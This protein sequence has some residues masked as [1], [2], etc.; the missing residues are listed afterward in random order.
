MAVEI[1]RKLEVRTAEAPA[2]EAGGEDRWAAFRQIEIIDFD[3]RFQFRH[4]LG[5]LSRFFVELE[6]HRLMGTRCAACGQ[7]WLPPRVLCPEDMQVTE[8]VELA[9]HGIL[10]AVSRSAYTL[11]SDGGGAQTLHLGYV[12]VEGASTLMLQQIRPRGGVE[13][14]SGAVVEVVWAEGT[15]SHP[16]ELFWFEPR[17]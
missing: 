10:A 4:S 12:A 7:V 1:R 16:M 14:V 11:T 3:L 13:P 17:V 6:N 2:A 15:V 5:K 9:Q 8:W